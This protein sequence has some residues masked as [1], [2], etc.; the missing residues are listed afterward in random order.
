MTKITIVNSE[1]TEELK[2][3]YPYMGLCIDKF[4]KA[5]TLVW[6]VAPCKGVEINDTANEY[7]IDLFQRWSESNFT[8]I[9]HMEIRIIE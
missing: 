6:F 5:E 8:P 7:T 9:K 4:S 3:Q 1:K 2:I